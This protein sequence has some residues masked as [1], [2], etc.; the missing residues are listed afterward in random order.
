MH[1]NDVGI[2][3]YITKYADDKQI[4]KAVMTVNGKLNLQQGLNKITQWS[5]KYNIPFN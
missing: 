1:D 4:I 3:H 2:N 5:D